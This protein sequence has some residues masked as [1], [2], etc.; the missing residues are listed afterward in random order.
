M[1]TLASTKTAF[2]TWRAARANTA[3]PIP[4]KLWDM[5]KHLLPTHKQSKI[6]K[7]LRLSGSQI[8]KYCNVNTAVNN[9]KVMKKSQEL[10]SSTENDFV[11]AMPLPITGD[12]SMS[13]LTLKG[14]SRSLHL[15]LPTSA[16]RD[17]LSM[18][19]ELL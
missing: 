15:R 2:E 11:T 8:K 18:L 5:V 9:Q 3:T 19:G 10:Q 6:C 13:E 1:P 14:S 16:L 7:V 17:V 4:A 12:A